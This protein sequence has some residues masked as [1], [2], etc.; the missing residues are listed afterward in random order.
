M[1]KHPVPW[2]VSCALVLIPAR[3]VEA[4]RRF[5]GIDTYNLITESATLLVTTGA[6][7]LSPYSADKLEFT[8]MLPPDYKKDSPLFI[9]VYYLAPVAGCGSFVLEGTT[10]AQFQPG[11]DLVEVPI[12]LDPLDGSNT[13]PSQST[14]KIVMTKKYRMPRAAGGEPYTQGNVILAQFKRQNLDPEDT[15]DADLW[16]P[17]MRVD[18]TSP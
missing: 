6:Q 7:H 17:A 16:I 9:T 11:K 15:C 1:S 14:G 2:I 10:W 8:F 3:D 12:P 18:Y 4:A 5:I 13:L